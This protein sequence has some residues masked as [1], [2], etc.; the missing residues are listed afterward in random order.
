MNATFYADV[1]HMVT[2]ATTALDEA[3]KGIWRAARTIGTPKLVTH[4]KGSRY[5]LLKNR[6]HPSNQQQSSLARVAAVNE[7]ILRACLLKGWFRLVFQLRGRAAI[8]AL[9]AWCSQAR[10]C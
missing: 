4:L 9:D 6:D 5:A 7:S 3:R 1:F 2:G 8:R 10:R